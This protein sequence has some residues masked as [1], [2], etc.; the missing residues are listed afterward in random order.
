MNNP[1]QTIA[2]LLL[3]IAATQFII[4]IN[5][6]QTFYPGYNSS[7]NI[8]SDLGAT[9]RAICIIVEPSATIFNTSIITLGT[10]IIT[11]AI[12]QRKTTTPIFTILLTVAGIGALGAGAF[13]QTSGQPH[14]IMSSFALPFGAMSAIASY[15]ITKHPLSY[16]YA[17]L[18]GAALTVLFLLVSNVHLGLG[19]GMM[20]RMVAYLILIWVIL[21]GIHLTRSAPNGPTAQ[22][23]PSKT[24]LSK[25]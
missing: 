10:L 15:S 1:H 4:A 12:L 7:T 21:I 6:A 14:L 3:I 20:E 16:L 13:P 23:N 17:A 25:T 22:H 2:G 19:V 9:C 11:A 24:S 8:I 5:L 18:G